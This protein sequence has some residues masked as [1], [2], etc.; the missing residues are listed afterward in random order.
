MG[1]L[2]GLSLASNVNIS[3]LDPFNSLILDAGGGYSYAWGAFG[4]AFFGYVVTK[5]SGGT[6]KSRMWNRR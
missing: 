3:N 5:S 1:A 2:G 4:G 6:G